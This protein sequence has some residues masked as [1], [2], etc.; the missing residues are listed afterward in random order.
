[1]RARGEAHHE[2]WKC[3]LVLQNRIVKGGVPGSV[4]AR[5]MT[6]QNIFCVRESPD[7][8]GMLSAK[9]STS[10]KLARFM[11]AELMMA[12][13]PASNNHMLGCDSC[14]KHLPE[15]ANG[16]WSLDVI[17]HGSATDTASCHSM[18]HENSGG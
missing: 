17:Q 10:W 5:S 8:G 7:C 16:F 9:S 1:M 11:A 14:R 13:A 4:G 12:P 6:C 3:C 15:A 18:P 2:I